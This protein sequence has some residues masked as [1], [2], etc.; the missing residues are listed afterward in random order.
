[1]A[2]KLPRERESK[3][4]RSIMVRLK[5][6]GIVLHRR[7]VGGL[8]D[9]AG[10]YVAF[11]SPGQSDLWGWQLDTG[12]HWEIEVKRPGN[13]PTPKQLRW[14]KDCTARNVVAFW[15]DNCNTVERVAEAILAGGRVVWHED[16]NFD[17]EG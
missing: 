12:R 16:E 3:V 15:G 6:L 2:T 17:V 4:Q 5:R 1:M 9:H 11:G 7:N 14:L 8:R 10:Q 13:K